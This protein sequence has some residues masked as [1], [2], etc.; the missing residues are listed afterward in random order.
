MTESI[1]SLHDAVTLYQPVR[2]T[3][4]SSRYATVFISAELKAAAR[5]TEGTLSFRVEP[6][7]EG[8]WSVLKVG[9]A[10]MLHEMG[11]TVAEKAAYASVHLPITD[12]RAVVRAL[13]SLLAGL[14]HFAQVKDHVD[15]GIKVA[16]LQSFLHPSAVLAP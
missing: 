1:H 13:A 6:A 5:Y 4:S 14:V 11:L 12:E 7:G 3:S 8:M 15:S 9:E 16:P 10:S 2:G